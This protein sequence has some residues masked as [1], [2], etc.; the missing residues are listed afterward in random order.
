MGSQRAEVKFRCNA[1]GK[2]QGCGVRRGNGIYP[3]GCY[4][5]GSLDSGVHAHAW[6][7]TR[8]LNLCMTHKSAK[9]KAYT[10]ILYSDGAAQISLVH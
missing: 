4:K 9:T 7:H 8:L 5:C 2:G 3:K 6:S 10:D 1:E